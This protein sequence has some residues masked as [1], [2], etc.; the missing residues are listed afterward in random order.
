MDVPLFFRSLK[1]EYKK[2]AEKR[3]RV[4]FVPNEFVSENTEF[5]YELT[6]L[7]KS[8]WLSEEGV[9]IVAT[10]YTCSDVDN[11]DQFMCALGEHLASKP[12]RREAAAYMLRQYLLSTCTQA[13]WPRDQPNV[14]RH[15][16]KAYMRLVD[17]SDIHMYGTYVRL[18]ASFNKEDEFRKTIYHM[19]NSK[20]FLDP[21][22]AMEQIKRMYGWECARDGW[23]LNTDKSPKELVFEA[24]YKTAEE[25][26]RLEQSYKKHLVQVTEQRDFMMCGET[27]KFEISMVLIEELD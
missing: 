27:N 6:L 21:R 3:V 15:C 8:F 14:K 1:K 22:K 11:L 9:D 4:A 13:R 24:S 12:E 25:R 10:A 26:E 16:Y 18:T 19:T 23:V 20:M 7:D 2:T 17:W 5:L